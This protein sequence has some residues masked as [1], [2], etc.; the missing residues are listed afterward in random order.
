M[1]PIFLI[2]C[3]IAFGIMM[4]ENAITTNKIQVFFYDI[5]LEYCQ[6]NMNKKNI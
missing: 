5:F 2:Y 1:I 3:F 6:R 4:A